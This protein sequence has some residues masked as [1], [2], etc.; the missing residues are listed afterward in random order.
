MQV[1]HE[2]LPALSGVRAFGHL[3]GVLQDSGQSAALPLND[4]LLLSYRMAV[5]IVAVV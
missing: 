2:R 1:E 4:L 5:V 3:W